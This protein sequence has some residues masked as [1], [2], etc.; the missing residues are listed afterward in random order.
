MMSQVHVCSDGL[1][2]FPLS[3]DGLFQCSF[4]SDGVFHVTLSPMLLK[5]LRSFSSDVKVSLMP[6]TALMVCYV[7][8]SFRRALSFNVLS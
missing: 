8:F 1:S 5:P 2:Q 6:L 7:P 4:S 3:Y